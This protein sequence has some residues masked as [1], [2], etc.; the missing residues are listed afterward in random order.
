MGVKSKRLRPSPEP[1]NYR[2]AKGSG[3]RRSPGITEKQKAPAVAGAFVAKLLERDLVERVLH[4]R[5]GGLQLR[6]EA[7]HD[8]DNGNRNAGR[9]QAILD[10]G[11]ARLVLHETRNEV[12]H[13]RLLTRSTRGC[14]SLVYD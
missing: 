1:R 13:L 14:L 2:K 12:L 11:R 3:R 6:A 5:E 10:G 8:G 7:L 4:R 9:D